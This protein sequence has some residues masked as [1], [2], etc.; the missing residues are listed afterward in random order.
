MHRRER[1]MLYHVG[2]LIIAVSL[3]LPCQGRAGA[4]EVFVGYADTARL[5][6]PLGA[7]PTPWL[8]DP[9]ILDVGHA[10][11]QIFD[12]G[13]IRIDNNTGAPLTVDKVTVDG[14]GTGKRFS[15]WGSF[16]IPAGM[17]A[18]LTQTLVGAD[19]FF[20]TS[21]E[22]FRACCTPLG[23]GVAPFPHVHL[24]MGSQALTFGDVTHVL[25]TQGFDGGDLPP[26]H[27]NESHPW[28]RT[29]PL[30]ERT[31]QDVDGDG[32]T[33]LVWHH[34]TTG[35]VLVWLLDG[36]APPFAMTLGTL[37]DLGWQIVGVGDVNGDGKADLVWHHSTTGA[38]LVWLLDGAAPPFAMTIETV[39]DLGWQIVGVGDV[40]GDGIADLVWHHSTTGTVV[41]W[42]LDGA[43]PPVVIELD[44]L[45][46]LGWQIVGVGDVNDDGK[47][48]LVWHH[49][50][51]GAVL[52]W[53]LDGAAPPFAMTIGTLA[54]LGW[55]N[56]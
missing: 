13:A 33:D 53:L 52:V 26:G 44:T 42:L 55:Q 31:A 14:F 7:F 24:R 8:G 38:V 46:D 25:D 41:V 20:D 10:A 22:T 3:L 50:T 35:A 30:P 4:I 12:A 47:A 37:A 28:T 15:L 23:V 5:P 2:A 39:A 56:K 45:A 34:S 49:S 9:G 16:T 19:S 32:M 51:T 21:D 43:A 36:A 11:G 1:A 29:T 18:I 54:D 17:K 48:D 27:T 40:N 6:L